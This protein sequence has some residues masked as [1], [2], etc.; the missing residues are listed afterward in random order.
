MIP[1]SPYGVAK[2]MAHALVRNYREAYKIFAVG[3]ILF[4][5]ESRYRGVEFVSRKITHGIA[6]ILSG[7]SKFIELGNLD[8]CRDWG[9]AGD[10]MYMAWLMLQQEQPKD[11]VV[12]TGETHSVK[13]FLDL[14]F[15]FVGINDWSSYIK[16]NSEFVRPSE[17]DILIG[18]SS[19]AKKELHWKPSISFQ[20]LVYDMIYADCLR[21]GVLNKVLLN[22]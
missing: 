21:Q 22:K 8:A 7:E 16:I 20:Q 9:F 12:A 11:Y 18:D 1:R 15:S 13:E 6:A 5:H 19:L 14:S 17:V 4:N 10:Y 2:L 3:G